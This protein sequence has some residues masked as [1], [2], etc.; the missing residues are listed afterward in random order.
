MKADHSTNDK[1]RKAVR[2]H[3]ESENMDIAMAILSLFQDDASAMVDENLF[4]DGT[5]D[6]DYIGAVV[7]A[8]KHIWNMCESFTKLK[9]II[10]SEK[11]QTV[12]KAI[13]VEECKGDDCF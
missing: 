4:P 2:S 10:C 5:K 11:L 6:K 9:S 3:L 1:L 7:E 12:L 13:E 8:E